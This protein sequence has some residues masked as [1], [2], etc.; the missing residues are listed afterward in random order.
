M[1]L[2]SILN[3]VVQRSHHFVRF[4]QP[5]DQFLI[6]PVKLECVLLC[7]LAGGGSGGFLGFDLFGGIGFGTPDA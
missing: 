4:V 1:Q 5:F 7:C 3:I 6:S 2:A